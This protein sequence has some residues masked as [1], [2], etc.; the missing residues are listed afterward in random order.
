VAKKPG[1]LPEFDQLD[2]LALTNEPKALEC[3]VV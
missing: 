3:S 2:E 1:N